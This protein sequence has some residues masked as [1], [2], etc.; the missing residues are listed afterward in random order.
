MLVLPLTIGLLTV[1]SQQNSTIVS[2]KGN[3]E[4]CIITSKRIQYGECSRSM[5]QQQMLGITKAVAELD[6]QVPHM[7][8]W[9]T[10]CMAEHAGIFCTG[11][12]QD[13]AAFSNNL[14]Q[15]VKKRK[16]SLHKKSNT[17]F[18]CKVTQK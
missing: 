2:N 16:V 6:W 3:N 14:G 13:N 12:K 5:L 18:A 7:V 1:K 10:F 15:E 11:R 9:L 8:A 4:D 17:L